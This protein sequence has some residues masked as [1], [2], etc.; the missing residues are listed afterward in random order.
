MP[1]EHNASRRHHIRKARYRVTKWPAYEDGLRRRGNLTF[2][3]DKDA[4][5]GWKAPRRTTPGGRPRYSDLAIELLLTLRPVFQFALCQAKALARSVFPLIEIDL[6][7]PDHS[8]LSRRG[9]DFAGRQPRIVQRGD[10]I[11]LVL[12]NT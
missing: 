4:L 9:R 2:W 8:I 10:C 11:H 7:T 6:A 1:F 3:F 5:A 12:D